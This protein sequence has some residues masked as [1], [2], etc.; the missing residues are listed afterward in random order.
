MRLNLLEQANSLGHSLDTQ[1]MG[2]T[3]DLEQED[4]LGVTHVQNGAAPIE[5]SPSKKRNFSMTGNGGQAN[6]L[7]R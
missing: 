2:M 5:P 7:S 4:A 3:D 1:L 6:R